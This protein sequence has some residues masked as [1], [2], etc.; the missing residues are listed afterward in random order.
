MINEH[1]DYAERNITKDD[2]G[3]YIPTNSILF[4]FPTSGDLTAYPTTNAYPSYVLFPDG[5]V[6]VD[7][8]GAEDADA[9]AEYF[10]LQGMRINTPCQGELVIVRKGNKSYK[11]VIR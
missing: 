2:K 11:T 4:T 10:N 7:S 8:V 3:I 5:G 6:G 1:P 9:P